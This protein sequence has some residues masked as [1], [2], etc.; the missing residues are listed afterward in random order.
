MSRS[1]CRI[2]L[3]AV[4]ITLAA[5]FSLGQAHRP[6]PTLGGAVH[7]DTGE[8]RLGNCGANIQYR[9]PTD[10]FGTSKEYRIMKLGDR[11]RKGDRSIRVS[12]SVYQ[13]VGVSGHQDFES[14]PSEAGPDLDGVEFRGA[15]VGNN[16][17][18]YHRQKI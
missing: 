14:V 7:L 5:L 17:R 12:G 2:E 4:S 8:E 10:T 6:A 13:G 15:S 3:R 16:R 9:T 18:S 1:E 11:G